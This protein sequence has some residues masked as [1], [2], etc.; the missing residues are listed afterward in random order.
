MKR[1]VLSIVIFSLLAASPASAK[2]FKNCTELRKVYPKGVAKSVKAAGASGAKVN[3]KAYNENAK[4][5]RDKDGI[6][7]EVA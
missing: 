5:D 4:S 1:I 7:C 2:T 3:R 6:A